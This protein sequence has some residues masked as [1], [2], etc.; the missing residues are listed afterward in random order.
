MT[1]KEKI[2]SAAVKVFAEK[3]KHGATMDEIAKKAKVNKAMLYYFFSTR[4]NIYLETVSFILKTIIIHMAE[5]LGKKLSKTNDPAKMIQMFVKDHLRAF[6]ENMDYTKVLLEAL[7]HNPEEMGKA[8][9]LLK[10][11]HFGPLKS[12]GKSSPLEKIFRAGID[13]GIFRKVDITQTL[14]SI[15]GMMLIYFISKPISQAM[16]DIGVKNEGSFLKQREKSIIDL[17][18][19]GIMTDGGSRV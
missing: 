10:N 1:T 4:E 19:H 5:K 11:D 9:E 12:S 16:L 13:K 8:A 2:I 3:G 17:I 6:S 15:M 7:I 18:F 14:I